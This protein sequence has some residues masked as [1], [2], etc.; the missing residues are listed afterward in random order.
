MLKCRLALFLVRWRTSGTVIHRAHFGTHTGSMF[1][2]ASG[3]E[4]VDVIGKATN[5]APAKANIGQPTIVALAD[6][7][8]AR[9]S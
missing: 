6:Y 7:P 2:S 9:Y 4:M 8:T 5:N 1:V 3:F